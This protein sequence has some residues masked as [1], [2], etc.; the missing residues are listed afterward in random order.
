MGANRREHL[1]H[2]YNGEGGTAAGVRHV[3]Y[4]G[5]VVRTIPMCAWP[6]TG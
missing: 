5:V 1:R 6:H 2:D 3:F 4:A